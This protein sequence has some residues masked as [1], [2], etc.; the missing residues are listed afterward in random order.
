MFKYLPKAFCRFLL[1][2]KNFNDR[3]DVLHNNNMH[4]SDCITQPFVPKPPQ[5]EVKF[6]FMIANSWL[7]QT[8]TRFKWA[9]L[10]IVTFLKANYVSYNPTQQLM[11]QYIIY[12]HDK[13][14]RTQLLGPEF[15]QA[16]KDSIVSYMLDHDTDYINLLVLSFKNNF[17]KRY[18]L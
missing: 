15:W 17:T 14:E 18:K 5:L 4:F 12:S 7:K 8:Q 1:F 6:S 13:R 2:H 10:Q 16:N 11:L 9:R 3:S